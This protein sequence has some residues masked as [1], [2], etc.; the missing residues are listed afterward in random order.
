MCVHV[1]MCVCMCVYVC[2]C[3]CECSQ[4]A[5]NDLHVDLPF[6]RIVFVACSFPRLIM[7]SRAQAKSRRAR[8]CSSSGGSRRSSRKKG[9]SGTGGSNT[10]ESSSSTSGS[11]GSSTEESSSGSGEC[12]ESR[13][14]SE[15]RSS[16]SAASSDS[17]S[18]N[19][20]GDVLVWELCCHPESNLG[21]S[22]KKHGLKCKRLTLETRFDFTKREDCERACAGVSRR[23]PN[24][25]WCSAP[26]TA[27]TSM[28][29]FN[30]KPAQIKKLR[31]KRKE[32]KRLVGHCTRILLRAAERGA[33]IY[34][35]WPH[36]CQGW[37]VSEL[38]GLR[39]DLRKLGRETFEV[40][41]DGCAFGLRSLTKGYLLRKAW[42]VLTTNADLAQA[43]R[44]CPLKGKN[45]PNHEHKRIMRAD[46]VR[47]AFY[48]KAMCDAI[49]DRWRRAAQATQH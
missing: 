31:H 27:W 29:N 44:T 23:P 5:N 13:S 41:F 33:H 3:V 6:F 16:Q 21:K 24:H 10:E 42:R 1:C 36:S 19:I 45:G 15:E 4:K 46:T 38:V 7:G 12:R 8:C 22:C 30:R 11:G 2:V 34:F 37:N 47:S 28:Q 25:V 9:N 35:E 20:R 14:S 18:K 43:S 32:S 17:D 26:C 49:A 40:R 39:E 48:P